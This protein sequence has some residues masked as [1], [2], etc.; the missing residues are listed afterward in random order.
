MWKKWI[1]DDENSLLKSFTIDAESD[2]FRIEKFIKNK[3]D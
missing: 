1:E 2:K 3:D